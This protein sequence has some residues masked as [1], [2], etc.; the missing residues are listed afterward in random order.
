[1]GRF[2]L[3]IGFCILLVGGTVGADAPKTE[4]DV[5][6]QM[7]MAYRHRDGKGVKRDYAEA[8]RWAHLAA[9]RGDAGARDFVGW[10]YFQGL[11]VKRSPEIAAG[12]FKAAAGKSASAAWNLGQCY[13]A[14]LGVDQDVPKALE[15]WKK[16]AAMGQGRAASTAAMV[17]LSGEGIAP[18]ASEARKLA[19]RAAELND[20][21]GL[22][23]L[24]ELH[25]QAG[26]IEKARAN[27]TKVS[28]LK[29]VGPTGQPTQP[30]DQMAAQQGADLL[31]LIEYRGRKPDPGNFAIVPVPHIAQ[32]WN[33]CGA[34]SCAM[35]AR[36][37]GKKLGGWD[38]KKLC[39][40]PLGT[41]TDW[42]D[43][44]KASGKIDLRWKLV[45][46]T[47]DDDGFDKATAFLRTELDAG[48]PVVIDFK[49]TG[50]DYP[51]GEAGHTLVVA[52]YIA[53]E[54]LYVL[55]NPAIAT[56]GLQLIT[57][58]DLKHYWRSDHYGELSKNVLSRPAI[59][60]DR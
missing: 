60:I 26:E 37:Q 54:N 47:P 48:R 19:E 44:L 50:P 31:K 4:G 3:A 14:G 6:A 49:F 1:M 9:D 35:L 38:F 51:N 41:G 20:P 40:S 17:Y 18:N 22:V 29:P 21:T 15:L 10:M 39:P 11:G 12:Y 24:G 28:Q 2:N 53:K 57:A 5:Q 27:W 32:G 8:L 56:P 59:V 55:C 7:E 36:A 23:L 58:K 42:G 13:F 52:G 33:N 46:F 16:A 30:S 45:T 43:L 34:T 25:F